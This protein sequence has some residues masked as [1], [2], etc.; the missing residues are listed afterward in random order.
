MKLP[1]LSLVVACLPFIAAPRGVCQ[2]QNPQPER[3][4]VTHTESPRLYFSWMPTEHAGFIELSASDAQLTFSPKAN[5][6]SADVES[7]LLLR[8]NVQVR[9]CA[10]SGHGCEKSSLLL[11]ADAVDFNEKTREIDAHGDIR[12]IPETDTKLH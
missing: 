5:L 4:Y 9:L 10:P 3:P 11:Q 12:I 1:M 6:T 8:G 7:V 2:K